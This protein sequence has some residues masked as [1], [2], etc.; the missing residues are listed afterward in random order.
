MS[1]SDVEFAKLLDSPAAARRLNDIRC[2]LVVVVANVQPHDREDKIER[3]VEGVFDAALEILLPDTPD[4][5][6]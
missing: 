2:A 1:D 6:P 3:V 4:S 5:G